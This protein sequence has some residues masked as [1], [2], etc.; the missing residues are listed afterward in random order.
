MAFLRARVRDEGG[1]SI[2]ESTIALV[3][4]FGVLLTMLRTLD[5]GIRVLV[6]SRRQAA[7]SALA[8]ELLERARSLEWENTG[9]VDTA[10]DSD[11]PDDPPAD[12]VS[13][14]N[15]ADWNSEFGIAT[16]AA[17]NYTFEG[18]EIVF[19][20]PAATFAPFLSFHE[21]V[22]RDNT[23]FERFLFVTSDR[24]DPADPATERWRKLTALVQWIPPSG[25]RREVRVVT[26]VSLYDQPAQ[27]FL[28]GTVAFDGGFFDIGG[29]QPDGRGWVKGSARWPL[30]GAARPDLRATIALPTAEVT[31]VT[32]YV[33]EAISLHSG[34]SGQF[35]WSD[36]VAYTA[37][38]DQ[39]GKRADD[40]F[41]SS[42]PAN[43]PPAGLF[44]FP[45]WTQ[46]DPLDATSDDPPRD[47]RAREETESGGAQ[48][49]TDVFDA[50]AWTKLTP[51]DELPYAHGRMSSAQAARVWFLEYE[52]SLLEGLYDTLFDEELDDAPYQFA[53][54]RHGP[55]SA[56]ATPAL[57]YEGQVDRFQA[58]PIDTTRRVDVDYSW[59]GERVYLGYDDVYA[60]AI[61]AD[62]E[63]WIRVDLPAV[64]GSVHAGETV[65]PS[66]ITA[67]DIFL[68]YWNPTSRVYEGVPGCSGAINIRVITTS[69]TCSVTIS[70]TMP[71][72]SDHPQLDYLV[73][74]TL[75]V[76]PALVPIDSPNEVVHQVPSMVTGQVS[77]RVEDVR[78]AGAFLSGL[79]TQDGVIYDVNLSFGLGGLSASAIYVEP[80]P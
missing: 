17:G 59:Q 76:N 42:P 14:V 36:G 49:T 79:L 20:N 39:F 5:S 51:G 26:F 73:Q 61:D 34:M 11:C 21:E 28:K 57:R 40:D 68:W 75:T 24:I 47:L 54:F 67:G 38:P 27:P 29:S 35:D 32:D 15:C 6:E 70:F 13:G 41:G 8:N 22:T 23:T 46:A 78:I 53:F 64:S 37:G 25:F 33:S 31:A 10:N 44:S 55:E 16:N 74:A 72:V 63:G 4:I 58:T 66:G 3:I 60:Q 2:L 12:G 62:F 19:L 43:D 45:A 30:G 71:D 77:Y 48:D 65:P 69:Q 56:S 80:S 18:R 50:Q 1:F 9:L 52:G 7:A